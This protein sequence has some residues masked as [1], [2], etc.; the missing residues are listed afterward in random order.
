MKN[1][2]EI[3]KYIPQENWYVGLLFDEGYWFFKIIRKQQ[4]TVYMPYHFN[5]TADIATNSTSGWEAPADAQGRFYLEPQEEE[6]VYQTFVGISPSQIK[7]YLQYTQRED[8]MSLIAPRPVPGQIGFWDG[9][10]SPY[11]DPSPITELWTV[12]DLYPYFNVQNPGISCIDVLAYASFWIT[13]FTYQVIK[14]RNRILE[15]LRGNR[16]CTV[17]TMGDGDRPIKGP[18][19][20]IEDYSDYMVQPEEV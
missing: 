2:L 17:R 5:E 15:F 13:P 20:L 8:R 10:M 19:W 14:D 7:M 12:H 9:E 18:A 1:M 16:R 3:E 6:T 11:H 4:L